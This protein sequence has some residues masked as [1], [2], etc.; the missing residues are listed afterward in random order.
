MALSL[1]KPTA[2]AA[3]SDTTPEKTTMRKTG[4]SVIRCRPAGKTSS[5]NEALAFWIKALAQ[6][7]TGTDAPLRPPRRCGTR[8]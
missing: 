4:P 6:T 1:R 7:V 8:R 5:K 2:A 3:K